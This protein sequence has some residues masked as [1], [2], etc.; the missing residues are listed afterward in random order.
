MGKLILFCIICLCCNRVFAQ[1]DTLQSHVVSYDEKMV[2][3]ITYQNSSNTFFMTYEDGADSYKAEFIPNTQQRLVG[4]LSYK[5]IDV[6]VGF[7]PNFMKND[8]SKLE[9]NNFNLGFRFNYK[10]WYQSVTFIN[11]KGFF[12]DFNHLERFY[13]PRFRSTKLGGTTSY[14]FNEKFSY[15]TIFN[16]NQWQLKSAGSFVP[17]FS[18]YYTNLTSKDTP[19]HVHVDMYTFSLAPSYHYNWVISQKFLVS[20][21]LLVGAGINIADKEVTP[22]YEASTN[23]KL[24]Y[25]TD[26]FFTYLGINSTS[27][28][29]EEGKNEFYDSFADVKLSVGYRFDPPKKFKK[30]YN[31]VTRRIG[32]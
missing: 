28:F 16:Q 29:Q 15:K 9:S 13:L 19:D 31:D 3:S 17:N 11:Q 10:K 2:G 26:S 27:F 8:G 30:L 18:V 6:S 21:G 20:A 4:G 12:V 23:I 24:G 7:T 5:M 14:V 32:F 25:N 1:R 22:L